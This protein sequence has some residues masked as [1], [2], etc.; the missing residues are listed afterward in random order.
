MRNVVLYGINVKFIPYQMCYISFRLISILYYFE[1]RYPISTHTS[2]CFISPISS[3][4]PNVNPSVGSISK[5]TFAEICYQCRFYIPFLRRA[6]ISG[7]LGLNSSNCAFT[8]V[9][10]FSMAYISLS[11]KNLLTLPSIRTLSSTNFSA[12][13]ASKVYHYPC[14]HLPIL[15]NQLCAVTH[16]L[17]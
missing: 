11:L 5:P 12:A 4:F 1:A 15:T 10:I 14:I 7:T 6:T 17:L 9:D 3:T 8:R 2:D 16:K 13:G